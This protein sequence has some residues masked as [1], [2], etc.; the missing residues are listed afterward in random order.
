MISN[1]TLTSVKVNSEL[2]IPFKIEC[3]KKKFSFQKLSDRAIYLFLTN[4]E[5]QKQILN[6]TNIEL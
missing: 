2:W 4:E 5:F 6:Q 3:V 1:K